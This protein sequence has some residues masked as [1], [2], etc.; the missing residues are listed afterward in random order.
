MPIEPYKN[1]YPCPNPFGSYRDRGPPKEI[2]RRQS[3]WDGYRDNAENALNVMSNGITPADATSF[4]CR[5]E[6]WK[7]ATI[8]MHKAA[9]C[10]PVK[11]YLKWLLGWDSKLVNYVIGN[12]C[13]NFIANAIVLEGE[14]ALNEFS[15]HSTS[16]V[17]AYESIADYPGIDA[18][19]QHAH[20]QLD[21]GNQAAS[22]MLRRH[23]S[24][25]VETPSQLEGEGRQALDAIRR[26]N[27]QATSGPIV[28]PQ[29]GLNAFMAFLILAPKTEPI[30]ILLSVAS[31]G[32]FVASVILESAINSAESR[33]EIGQA[34][35]YFVVNTDNAAT[36]RS[37]APS[38]SPSQGT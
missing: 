13:S 34:Q 23:G 4:V 7:T 19:Q 21:R 36:E 24:S 35:R 22:D 38:P 16:Y 37:R 1:P 32:N 15:L 33:T 11:A 31:D 18:L 30:H 10:G 28:V 29:N 25:I 5:A 6:T 20:S 27:E 14:Q 26:A 8:E 9:G 3:I 17:M 2:A 12:W